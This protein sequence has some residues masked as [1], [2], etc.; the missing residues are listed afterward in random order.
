MLCW[1][2]SADTSTS[3][4]ASCR[5]ASW[6]TV[7]TIIANYHAKPGKGDEVAAILARHVALTRAEPGCIQFLV[8]RSEDDP[9]SIRAI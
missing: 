9:R 4:Y 8:N 6:V 5:R 7:L 2:P 1:K 3:P